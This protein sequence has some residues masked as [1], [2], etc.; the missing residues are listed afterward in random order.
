VSLR[1]LQLLQTKEAPLNES[2]E[3]VPKPIIQLT[4]SP[5]AGV[6][7]ALCA[8]RDDSAQTTLNEHTAETGKGTH[9]SSGWGLLVHSSV[10]IFVSDPLFKIRRVS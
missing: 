7:E 10:R 2:S 6:G 1:L 9:W 3:I 8:G 4:G 5:Q